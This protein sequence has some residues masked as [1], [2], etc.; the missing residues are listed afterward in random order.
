MNPF[1]YGAFSRDFR[2]AFK[3]L[4]CGKT[5][6][7]YASTQAAM[8]RGSGPLNK[9]KFNASSR[10]QINQMRAS[11]ASVLPAP[12]E[13]LE[14]A[15]C[16]DDIDMLTKGVEVASTNRTVAS[17]GLLAVPTAG[18]ALTTP[19]IEEDVAAEREANAELSEQSTLLSPKTR[20]IST[21]TS[22]IQYLRPVPPPSPAPLAGIETD[23][24]VTPVEMKRLNSGDSQHKTSQQSI[25][26]LKQESVTEQLAKPSGECQSS[27]TN[28]VSRLQSVS[29]L[30]TLSSPSDSDDEEVKRRKRLSRE[31]RKKHFV[32]FIRLFTLFF[33][34]FF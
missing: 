30:S 27:R 12:R 15:T 22:S 10:Y 18:P 2:A 3:R 13:E 26:K 25:A 11:T 16:S 4:I 33:F 1:I 14:E 8:V 6:R 7:T 20:C 24:E 32:S 21:S 28:K 9:G 5:F 17:G 29:S 34:L 31:R 19:T 23:V